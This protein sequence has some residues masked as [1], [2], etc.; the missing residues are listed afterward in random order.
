MGTWLQI[1]ADVEASQE[2]APDLAE[3]CD[4]GLFHGE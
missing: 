4:N 1:I 3:N 2:E